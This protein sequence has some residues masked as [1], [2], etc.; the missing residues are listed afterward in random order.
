[1]TS[2]G[3][4]IRFF[5]TIQNQELGERLL[6]AHVRDIAAGRISF[7]RAMMKPRAVTR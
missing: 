2:G 7:G 5:A 3:D 4:S 6:R 1:V